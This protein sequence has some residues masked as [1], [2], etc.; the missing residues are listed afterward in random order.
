MAEAAV[1]RAEALD[2]SPGDR[3]PGAAPGTHVYKLARQLL[4]DPG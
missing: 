2:A 1:T 3:W 4:R